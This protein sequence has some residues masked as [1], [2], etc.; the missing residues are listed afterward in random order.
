MVSKWLASGF[1]FSHGICFSIRL[2]F[3]LNTKHILSP[4]TIA[5][6]IPK[7]AAIICIVLN[8]ELCCIRYSFFSISLFFPF[9][10]Q[11]NCVF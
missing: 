9:I 8:V 4:T 2:F 10:N 11:I 3:L 5:P 6:T 7:T 1:G